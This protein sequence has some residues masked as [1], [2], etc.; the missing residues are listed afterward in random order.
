MPDTPNWIILHTYVSSKENTCSGI[1]LKYIRSGLSSQYMQQMFNGPFYDI[2][3]VLQVHY[4]F[5]GTH[6]SV[7]SGH[8]WEQSCVPIPKDNLTVTYLVLYTDAHSI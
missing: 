3:G 8:L 6:L 2:H 7:V 5:T 4:R 1:V